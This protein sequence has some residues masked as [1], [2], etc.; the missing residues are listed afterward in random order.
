MLTFQEY[1]VCEFR[2]DEAGK[3]MCSTMEMV[4]MRH[5]TSTVDNSGE[6]NTLY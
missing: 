4:D 6:G 1:V 5:P 3:H 2:R